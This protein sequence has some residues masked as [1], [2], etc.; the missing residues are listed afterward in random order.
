[1]P[2]TQEEQLNRIKSDMSPQ[3][4]KRVE[5]VLDW[6]SDPLIQTRP[7]FRDMTRDVLILFGHSTYLDYKIR[8]KP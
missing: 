1:M 3:F 8:E 7:D 2:E 5:Y 6:I 4:Q